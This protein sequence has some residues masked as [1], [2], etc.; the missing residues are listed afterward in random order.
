VWKDVLKIRKEMM[1]GTNNESNTA[2][3]RAASRSALLVLDKKLNK[4]LITDAHK[5]ATFLNPK[6]RHLR[7]LSDTEKR[8]VFGLLRY[9]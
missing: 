8:E 3:V 6:T 7:H 9:D 1:D 5:I 2:L 4:G